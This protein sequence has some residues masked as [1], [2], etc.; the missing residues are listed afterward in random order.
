VA[1]AIRGM[2]LSTN[3]AAPLG[4]V[5][6]VNPTIIEHDKEPTYEEIT[7]IGH[8][9]TVITWVKGGKQTIKF[10]L[11]FDSTQAFVDSGF[12]AFNIPLVG[13]TPPEAVLETMLRPEEDLLSAIFGTDA[14]VK[15]PPLLLLIVGLRFW[16][17]RLARA[18]IRETLF[19][20]LMMPQRFTTE[21]EF[22]VIEHGTVFDAAKGVRQVLSLVE[23]TVGSV[24]TLLGGLF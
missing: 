22:K 14:V 5:F 20:V 4:L 11:F 6:P 15:P 2:L 12:R 18:P 9:A 1:K 23:T 8:D 17:V 24:S 10:R 13:V 19:D 3:L 7:P 16:E 21:L